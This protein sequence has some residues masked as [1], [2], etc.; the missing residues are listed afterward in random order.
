MLIPRRSFMSSVAISMAMSSSRFGLAPFNLCALLLGGF[1]Q[2]PS[3]Y[4]DYLDELILVRVK[5]SVYAYNDPILS[6]N[7]APLLD[8]KTATCSNPA[9]P[10][11]LLVGHSKGA[12]TLARWMATSPIRD[13]PCALIEPVDVDPPNGR[14]FSVLDLWETN[15]PRLAS[16]PTLIV[17]APFTDT[18]RRY[19][20]AKNL[21]APEGKDARAFLSVA[22]KARFMHPSGAAPL[23]FVEIKTLGHNDVT[24]SALGGCSNGPGR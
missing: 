11:G 13:I 17:S 8:L 9:T 19:G 21:C 10:I 23:C 16:I 20:K 22:L 15:L 2:P 18:S 4:D 1:L 7:D 5:G 24:S 14:H 12:K 6:E 3:A